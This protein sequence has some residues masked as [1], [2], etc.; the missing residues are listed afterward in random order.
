[1]SRRTLAATFAAVLA[2][3]SGGSSSNPP[4][5]Q[6]TITSVTPVTTCSGSAAVG[7][8]VLALT[9]TS[10]QAGASVALGA[11]VANN[12]AVFGSTS[13]TAGFAPGL[14]VGGPYDVTLTNP[15]GGSATKPA[16]VR[17]VANLQVFFVDPPVVYNGISVQA[18]VYGSGFTP[19]IQSVTATPSGGGSSTTLASLYDATHPNQIQV[20]VPKS[21]APGTYDLAVLDATGCTGHLAGAFQVTATATLTLV[22]L[23]PAFGWMGSDTG[24]TATASAT[25]PS[26]GFKPVPRL[27]LNPSTPAPG[28]VASALGAVA[29]GGSTSLSAVVP[30]GLVP[31]TY[32]LVA[33]NP[34]GSVGVLPGA[35]KVTTLPP[36]SVSSLSPGSLPT[37]SLQPFGILGS[38][39]R[40]PAVTLSC[41]SSTGAAVTAPAVSVASFTT[42]S[43][44]ASVNAPSGVAVCVVRVTDG[45]DGSFTDFS[46]LVFANP[47]QNLYPPRAGPSLLVARRAPVALGG[48]ATSAARFLHVAGG[49]DGTGAAFDT[50]ESAPLDLF[51]TPSTFVSQR[52]RLAHPRAFAGGALIGRFL[53]LAGGSASGTPLATVERAYV[54]DPAQRGQVTDLFVDVDPGSAGLGAGLWYY[55]VAAVMGTGDTFNPGGENLP[56]DPFPVQLPTLS[57][58]RF[59]VTVTWKAIAGAARYRVYRSPAANAIAGAEQVIAEVTAPSTSYKDTGAAPVSA[60]NPLPVGSLGSWTTLAATLSVPREGPAVSWAADP[61]DATKA[62]L[63]VLGGRQSATTA[64]ASYELLPLAIG[65]DGSQTPAATGFTTGT[66][67]L[68]TA[69]WQL[70]ASRATSQLSSSIPAGQTFI[71]ALSGLGAAGSVVTSAD[72]AQVATGGQLSFTALK[73][74][75][76]AGYATAAAGNF[77]YAF[78]GANGAPDSTIVSAEICSSG[79]S[80]CTANPTPSAVVNWNAEGVSMTTPRVLHGGALSGAF[81]YLAGG[82]TAASPLTLTSSTEY[83]LW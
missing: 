43:I 9:G 61:N 71:Y 58:K 67:Q 25:A 60:D 20:T 38:D 48:D 83:F 70:A 59:D 7:S 33:V 12:V 13:A 22:S 26:P 18:T 29:Y 3:C 8:A 62:Y 40:A 81:M 44:S 53:Y 65:V 2:A 68:G 15:D 1:M 76:R 74:L 45:D 30:S 21:M 36:P 66:G 39:F 54:L 49:D 5:S 79:L 51:G 19:P 14:P 4:P 52:T 72:A 78:G 77:V 82:V 34:D 73:I 10:F 63:Y 50:V 57:G 32:D 6:P 75:N 31:S 42:T 11:A 28:V 17:V 47:A 23:S 37:G 64:L 24:V 69:R 41:V 27:Y 46:A 80:A 16:A 35:F 55:R 56:A